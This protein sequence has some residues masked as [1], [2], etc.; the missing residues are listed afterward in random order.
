M[1]KRYRIIT[2][3]GYFSQD[4]RN[5]AAGIELLEEQLEELEGRKLVVFTNYRLTNGFLT[6]RLKPYKAQ[7]IYGGTSQKQNEVSLDT[8]INDKACRCIVMNCVAGGFGLDGLQHVAN[9]VMFLEI[10]PVP[11][12]FHQAAARLHRAGQHKNVQVRVAVANRTCNVRQFKQ[13]M[14]KDALVNRVVRGVQDLRDAI[15]GN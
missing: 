15:H 3:Y 2:N 12:W 7:M 9:D 10:P 1:C 14:D 13:L 5:I 11:A 4:E 8:F 6:E